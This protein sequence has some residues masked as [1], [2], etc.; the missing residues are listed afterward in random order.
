MKASKNVVIWS[1]DTK[2]NFCHTDCGRDLYDGVTKSG[3]WATMCRQCF[4]R[5]GVAVANGYGQHYR[6]NKDGQYVKAK[7]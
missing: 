4:R 7:F 1:G 5:H 3:P 6:K 2:C